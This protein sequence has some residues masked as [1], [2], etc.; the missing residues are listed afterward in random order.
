MPLLVNRP[1][2]WKLV[3]LLWSTVADGGVTEKALSA[4]NFPVTEAFALRMKVQG[5]VE[6]PE[7]AP[8]PAENPVK[9]FRGTDRPSRVTVDPDAK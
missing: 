3:R 4:E 2:A 9:R 8:V 6:Q 1:A 7:A 5:V